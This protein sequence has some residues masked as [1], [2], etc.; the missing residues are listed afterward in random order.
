MIL[1][2]HPPGVPPQVSKDE[3]DGSAFFASIVEK[4]ENLP[5]ITD[6]KGQENE[7]TF[8]RNPVADFVAY[9]TSKRKPITT[10]DDLS[11]QKSDV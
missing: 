7:W 4:G 3:L 2:P 5:N 11:L 6:E 8:D 1:E 9:W 10:Q